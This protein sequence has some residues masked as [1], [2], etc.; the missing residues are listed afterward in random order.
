MIQGFP[1]NTSAEPAISKPGMYLREPQRNVISPNT[2]RWQPG[3]QDVK[4]ILEPVG[5][6]E[7]KVVAKDTGQ[8]LA[9][10]SLWPQPTQ[11]GY[12]GGGDRKTAESGADGKFHLSDLSS[13]RFGHFAP[14]VGWQVTGKGWP[15]DAGGRAS[16]RLVTGRRFL[17]LAASG[18]WEG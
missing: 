10:F 14:K 15:G 5:R 13:S 12:F 9:G 7:G 6:I 8:P 16:E 11:G 1:T 2:M 4:L 3:Q 17:E 18:V